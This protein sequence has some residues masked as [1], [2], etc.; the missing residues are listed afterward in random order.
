[1]TLSLSKKPEF[2]LS[3]S[4]SFGQL[5]VDVFPFDLQDGD[6]P[7]DTNTG[8]LASLGCMTSPSVVILL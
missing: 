6:M 8:P 2:V 4:T 3:P 1:M 7:L 5:N